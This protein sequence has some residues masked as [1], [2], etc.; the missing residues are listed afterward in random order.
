MRKYAAVVAL[1]LLLVAVSGFTSGP[2]TKDNAALTTTGET[3]SVTEDGI[4]LRVVA[5]VKCNSGTI[6]V[7]GFDG[8]AR[9]SPLDPYG[10][11][12]ATVDNVV[13][14]HEGDIIPIYGKFTAVFWQGVGANAAG[15]I[16][17]YKE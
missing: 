17:I 14:I 7:A 13:T 9:Q 5:Y 15:T 3:I 10:D 11:D 4:P 8:T 6:G 16:Y 1:V 12:Y 2:I